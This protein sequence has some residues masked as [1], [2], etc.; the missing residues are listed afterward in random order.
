[1]DCYGVHQG[2]VV[3]ITVEQMLHN[4]LGISTFGLETCCALFVQSTESC[5]LFR[6]DAQ[7][8][9]QTVGDTIAQM[10]GLIMRHTVVINKLQPITSNQTR[11]SS[12]ILAELVQ[13]VLGLDNDTCPILE[14]DSGSVLVT[15]TDEMLYLKYNGTD[16]APRDIYARLLP[17]HRQFRSLVHRLNLCFG[18][19]ATANFFGIDCLIN[20][21]F[22]YSAIPQLTAPGLLDDLNELRGADEKVISDWLLSETIMNKYPHMGKNLKNLKDEDQDYEFY[23]SIWAKDLILPWMKLTC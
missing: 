14:S 16:L 22:K 9:V 20:A 12:V 2:E 1:M 13:N 5:A 15:A 11:H 18:N 19:E 21:D 10:S 23:A 4:N 7:T 6:I 17:H 3:V 8:N